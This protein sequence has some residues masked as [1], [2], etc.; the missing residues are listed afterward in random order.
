MTANAKC[1]LVVLFEDEIRKAAKL[2]HQLYELPEDSSQEE[3]GKC[4]H[5]AVRACRVALF[6]EA[7]LDDGSIVMLTSGD[8]F[9]PQK[10]R[11]L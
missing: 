3:Y 1:N 4:V 9:K 6:H 7:L 5:D 2:L 8:P 11:K 10:K